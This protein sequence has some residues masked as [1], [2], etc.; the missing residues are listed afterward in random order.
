[1][2]EVSKK[3]AMDV[4]WR[5]RKGEKVTENDL[6]FTKSYLS[7]LKSYGDFQTVVDGLYYSNNKNNLTLTNASKLYPKNHFNVTEI[8]TY[9]KCPYRY[10]VNFGIK[11]YYDENYDVD[12][13]ELGSI[14]HTSLEDVSRLIK[15]EDIEKI[16]SEQLDE[17][18]I[19]NFNTSVDN[20]LDMTRKNDPRNRFILNNIIK[21]TKNNSRE[22]INQL[23]K[24]EFKV[25]D[26]EVD[27]GYNKENDLPGVY[28]DDKNY[29]R[30]RID[31]IDKANNYL[32]IIDYKTGKKVFKIVNILNG[33]DLQLLVYMMSASSLSD[34]ITPIG[35]FYM[36]LSDEL[37]KMKDTYEKSNI[38][39]IYE[40]KF[41][42]NGLVVKVNEEV[43]KLID[44]ENF[45]SKNIGVIDIKNTDILTKEEEQVVNNFAKELI[46]KYIK[47]IKIGNIKLNP[48]RYNESQNEC[49]YCDFKG[50]CKFDE[51]IDTD[52]Y[53][54]FDSKKTIS[55][56]Y[57][58]TEDL[59]E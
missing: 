53:R 38:E 13:R 41:K 33:L 36:P 43:F 51:S 52:K 42:M 25:S 44:K 8:E 24:G 5:V 40:D 50:I 54:D 1:S 7:Y 35:S 19:E 55:D 34:T 21:N 48:I 39:K 56:L 57:K 47:E 15:D 20:Y 10:F 3:Y 46:S 49:Q 32:R 2:K 6:K 23:K 16:T 11:P 12:A 37:E 14:V 4:L 30:G 26:V 27:F 29:L 9:S 58:S 45:D 17:L 59:D 28:V 22:L 18:I 31:R